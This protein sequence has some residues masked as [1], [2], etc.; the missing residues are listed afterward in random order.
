MLQK[1][2]VG[3]VFVSII[4]LATQ[5]YAA[6]IYVDQSLSSNITNGTYNKNSRATGGSDGNAYR[7]LKAVLWGTN[8]TDGAASAGDTIL[9][10]G[11]TYK[12]AWGDSSGGSAMQ[13]S[14]RLSGTS[15]NSYTTIAS[16]PGEW[17]IIDGSTSGYAIG[18][19]NGNVGEW[20]GGLGHLE[21]IKFE[22]LG[23]TGG[24][25]GGLGIVMGPVWVRYC[26]I[27]ENGK[28]AS[29]DSNRGGV[30][31]RRGMNNIIEYNYFYNN[32]GTADHNKAHIINY[33]DYLYS[34]FDINHCNKGNIIRYNFFGEGANCG[35]KDKAS[36]FLAV[37]PYPSNANGTIAT[38]NYLLGN[39]IHH[40]IGKVSSLLIYCQQDFAQV[41][42]NIADG[43]S[44]TAMDGSDEAVAYWKDV[45]NN[46]VIKGFIAE[47]VGYN[48]TNKELNLDMSWFC[49]NN[50]ITEYGAPGYNPSIGIATC[51]GHKTAA[52]DDCSLTYTWT[53][54]T[55]DRNL[56]YKPAH[57]TWHIGQPASMECTNHPW[58]TVAGFNSAFGFT[59]YYSATDGLFLGTTGA[60]KYKINAAF[61]IG[62]GKYAGNG[63]EGGNHRYLSGVTIPSYLGAVDPNNS[64]WVDMV[65]GLANIQNLI[66]GGG[67]TPP[68]PPP[69]QQD[70]TPPASPGGVN[71]NIIQ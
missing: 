68:P 41:F 70:T 3:I 36:Q 64:G 39:R 12:E 1:K 50:I 44:I 19:G 20:G 49:A 69:V 59:N 14:Q 37:H 57:A 24:S 29:G 23:I 62:S 54:T 22:R 28:G 32:A 6:T 47:T 61:S 25:K 43:C 40:N 15:W 58:L 26:Y 34:S 35:Y 53:N 67:S 45:Y 38:T 52:A 10:R 42:N 31:L 46:T 56:I 21:Y 2:I 55:V 65:L 63:G 16:Y 66:A 71:V 11:G 18:L 4:L 51:W 30:V 5:L 33:S 60:D 27:Y 13:I 17:A 7:T 9:L 48:R 8:G